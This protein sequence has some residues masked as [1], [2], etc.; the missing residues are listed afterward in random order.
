MFRYLE[1]HSWWVTLEEKQ[2]ATIEELMKL[3]RAGEVERVIIPMTYSGYGASLIDMSNARA[4]ER[5]YR[6]ARFKNVQYNLT[7]SASQFLRN[8]HYREFIEELQE[9]YPVFDEQDYDELENETK[10][11]FIVGE[12][13]SVLDSKELFIGGK[14]DAYWTK[15]YVEL[16]LHDGGWLEGEREPIQWWEKVEIDNDGLTPYATEEDVETLAM[17]VQARSIELWGKSKK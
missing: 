1:K 4:I 10:L 15:H 14:K 11:E 13:E 3:C 17:A 7:M 16:V 9:Q 6:K 5:H 2:V 12:I 8:E